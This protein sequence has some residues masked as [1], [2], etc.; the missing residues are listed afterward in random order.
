[1]TFSTE[2]RHNFHV[3][4]TTVCHMAN[5]KSWIISGLQWRNVNEYRLPSK[6]AHSPNYCSWLAVCVHYSANIVG[7]HDD[8]TVDSCQ[9][10]K[11]KGEYLFIVTC[12]VCHCEI[13]YFVCYSLSAVV[14]LWW[15]AR[16]CQHWW[17]TVLAN[18]DSSCVPALTDWTWTE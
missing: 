17:L 8:L 15:H 2:G 12:F 16:R 7:W 6:N 4:R 9:K 18:I 14:L 3:P 10:R 1:V 11:R 5:Y 13:L